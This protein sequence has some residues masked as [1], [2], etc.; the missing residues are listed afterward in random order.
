M[1]SGVTLSPELQI[2]LI[3]QD[4]KNKHT[5]YISQPWFDMYLADRKSLVLNYNPF[6][7]F[8]NDETTTNQVYVNPQGVTTNYVIIV[9]LGSESS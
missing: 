8:K 9:K 3:L 6:I 4:K 1:L 5:S 7:A 2:E